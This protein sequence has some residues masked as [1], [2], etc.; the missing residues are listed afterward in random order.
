MIINNLFP[1]GFGR[2]LRQHTSLGYIQRPS[3]Y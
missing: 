2:R 3:I 1:F